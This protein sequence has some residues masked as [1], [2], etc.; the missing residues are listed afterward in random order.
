MFWT[1]MFFSKP[2]KQGTSCIWQACLLCLT[3]QRNGQ[4]GAEAWVWVLPQPC[5]KYQA[6]AT[7]SEYL[8]HLPCL[9]NED[10]RNTYL[11]ESLKDYMGRY[12]Q[13]SEES[14]QHDQHSV[15]GK[16]SAPQA[17]AFILSHFCPFKNFACFHIHFSLLLPLPSFLCRFKN[18]P[19]PIF[20]VKERWKP[21]LWTAGYPSPRY[22]HP[23]WTPVSVLDLSPSPWKAS[24]LCPH[25]PCTPRMLQSTPPP[26]LTGVGAMRH[27]ARRFWGKS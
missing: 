9:L 7:F 22:P 10:N 11:L 23:S 16:L 21:S 19:C 25:R 6:S 24:P 12:P 8:P 20:I 26:F 4:L 3:V 1:S 14:L 13:S 17:P 2:L 15:R 27:F 5:H 18:S